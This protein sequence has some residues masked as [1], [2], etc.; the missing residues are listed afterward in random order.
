MVSVPDYWLARFQA[1]VEELSKLEV[2]AADMEDEM[3]SMVD[4]I[5]TQGQMLEEVGVQPLTP[6]IFLQM[7]KG[8]ESKERALS[9]RE[10]EFKDRFGDFIPKD[11]KEWN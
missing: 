11:K 10:S 1:V 9:K 4:C 6:D 8:L 7:A 2:V 5:M 3:E